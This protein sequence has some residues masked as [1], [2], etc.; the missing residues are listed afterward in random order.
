ME[1]SM[2]VYKIT[3]LVNWKIYVGQHSGDD[4][5][6][7]FKHCFRHAWTCPDEK[8]YLYN[9]FRK[10][11][12]DAFVIESL[13]RPIDKQQMDALE[14]FFIRVLETQNREIGYNITAGGGGRLG[15]KRPHTDEEKA[16][17][18]EV[19]TGRKVTWG[20]KISAAQKGR[21]F[22]PEHIAALK[23]G[24][25]GCKKPPRSPEH[26]RKIGE[27]ARARW[28]KKKAAECQIPYSK[29]V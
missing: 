8:P 29:T 5:Q 14:I 7:Y 24:Q 12:E 3:N 25:K 2:H 11:G 9:A 15:T 18:S 10:Y 26:L 1:V 6:A 19:M 23:A 17:M 22:T 4:L 20:D 13:V 21:S 27:N 16:H 28:A